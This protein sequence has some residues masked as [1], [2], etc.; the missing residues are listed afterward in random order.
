MGQITFTGLAS[1]MD[2]SSWIEALVS[3]KQKSVT[4]LQNKQSTLEK[5]QSVLDTVKSSVSNLRNA[6]EK[7]TDAKFG[8]SFDLFAKNTVSSSN[9]DVVAASVT[10][11]AAR[12]SFDVVVN[13]LATTT[14]ATSTLDTKINES[15]RFMDLAS[16][17]AK[18]GTLSVYVNGDKKEINID[19]DDTLGRIIDKFGDIGIKAGIDENGKFWLDDRQGGTDFVVGSASDESNFVSVIGLV[20]E[21][22][23]Y[24]YNSNISVEDM[25]LSRLSTAFGSGIVG[26]FGISIDGVN[27]VIN[28]DSRETLNS[29]RR[30]FEDLGIR[31]RFDGDGKLDLDG[32]GKDIVIGSDSDVSNFVSVFGLEKK[33][34]SYVYKSYNPVNAF[35]TSQKL[36][37]IF[38]DGIFGTFTIGNQEFNIDENTTL[39]SLIGNINSKP[40]AGVEAYWDASAGSLVLKSKTEGAFNINIESGSSKFTEIFG[41][42]NDGAIVNGTQVLGDYA[43]LSING[44]DII[45]SSNTVTSDIT[46][47]DGLTLTLKSVSKENDNGVREATNISVSQ[48]T[49]TLVDALKS[50]INSYNKTI[51]TIDS[52]TSKGEA[53]YGDTSLTSLRNN[54]RNSAMN[55]NQ[56]S[57]LKLLANIGIT[58]G[59]ASNSTDTSN[60]N[61]LQLDEEKFKEMLNENPDAVKALLLGDNKGNNNSG[62]ILNK[63]EKITEDSL[64][65]A[66][67]YFENK[68]KSYSAQVNSIKTSITNT[69]LRVDAYRERLQK[70]FNAMEQAIASMQQNYSKFAI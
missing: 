20:K 57:E 12:Q 70:Q 16:G 67:G 17:N 53:L 34:Y 65:A 26:T 54:L 29:L 24:K 19:E 49:D 60:V 47:I 28:I 36:G 64:D 63:L 30:K 52:K 7:L 55:V 33:P 4:T 58:T 13:R 51:E 27:K 56:S 8:G 21:P 46:G 15:T 35:D 45:S 3:I 23:S 43:Q 14:T 40:D 59:S 62:G 18:A 61:K 5:S 38:G 66:K 2:T 69:Q 41:F 68:S 50:F 1:G 6:V 44:T 9:S 31:A 10:A 48:D 32:G 22:A 39:K 25:D 11:E 42:T 37:K